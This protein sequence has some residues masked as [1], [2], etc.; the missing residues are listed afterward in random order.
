[1]CDALNSSEMKGRAANNH[2]VLKYMTVRENNKTRQ[3][4]SYFL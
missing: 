4:H 3:H 1:M 2:A